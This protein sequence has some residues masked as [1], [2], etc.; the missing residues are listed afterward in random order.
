MLQRSF[1]EETMPAL[2]ADIAIIGAGFLG[3]WSAF[4]AK[5]KCPKAHIILVEQE[6]LQTRASTRNAGFACFG[7]PSEIWSD[8]QLNGEAAAFGLVQQRWEGLQLIQQYFSSEQLQ[9]ENDGGYECF[10]SEFSGDII[11]NINKNLAAI[12]GAAD[13]FT[14][15]HQ[16]LSALGLQGFQQL[17]HNQLESQLHSGAYWHA[18]YTRCLQ[19]GIQVVQGVAIEQIEKQAQ[20]FALFHRQ[21]KIIETNTVL[22]ATNALSNNLWPMAEPVQPQ[23]GS[24]LVTEPLPNLRL[25][26]CFHY[27]EGYYYFRNVGNRI[28]LGG[29]RNTSFATENTTDTQ[30]HPTIESA[31]HTF[32]HKHFLVASEVSISHH[33][34]GT[35]GF[36]AGKMPVLQQPVKD[37][38]QACG[39]NG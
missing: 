11:A 25:K 6:V 24:I 28:L 3:L 5:Q 15:Q 23:R 18:M 12:V 38:Y 13:C 22:L 4:L 32:L 10:D 14:P 36:T 34:S 39:C 19:M 17:Y 9:W 1:W 30:V 16:R 26:G 8:V 20:G 2:Q 29:A 27:Q 31:L 21:K 35:M 33:W 7:S 37:L